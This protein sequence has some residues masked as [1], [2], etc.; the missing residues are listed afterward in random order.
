[1]NQLMRWVTAYR[2]ASFLV[3]TPFPRLEPLDVVTARS[4]ET[5]YL[6]FRRDELIP[7]DA[8]T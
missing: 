6:P 2:S 7:A 4:F 5:I 1:M 8:R 3:I